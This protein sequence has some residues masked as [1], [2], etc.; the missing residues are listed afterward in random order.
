MQQGRRNVSYPCRRRYENTNHGGGNRLKKKR[1]IA[2]LNVSE[3]KENTY[4]VR[5]RGEKYVAWITTQWPDNTHIFL[6][7]PTGPFYLQPRY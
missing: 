3:E 6:Q 2:E 5:S 7:P 4:G 1:M